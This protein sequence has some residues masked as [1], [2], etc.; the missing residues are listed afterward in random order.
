MFDGRREGEKRGR[1]KEGRK[2]GKRK[3]VEGRKA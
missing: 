1:P 2:V 3:R